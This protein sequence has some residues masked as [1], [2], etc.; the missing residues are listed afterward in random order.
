MATKILKVC[1]NDFEAQLIKGALE[2]EGIPCVLQGSNS[3]FFR[4]GYGSQSAFPV[5][6]LVEER[7]MEK[8][9]LIIKEPES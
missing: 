1:N 6:V 5:N 9:L 8:A 3:S 2:G 7:D 4:A